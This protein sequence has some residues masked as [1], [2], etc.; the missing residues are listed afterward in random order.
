MTDRLVTDWALWCTAAGHAP[1]TIRLRT[2]YVGRCLA[3]REAAS[4]T[5]ADVARFLAAPGWRPA[6]R[7]SAHAA[8]R[9][10][11]GWAAGA[12][13]L[14]A[15]PTVGLRATRVPV[16]VP[17]PASDQVIATALAAADRRGRL[18]LL[19]AATM[20]LRRAE[21]A[22]AHSRDVVDGLLR[23][24]G[25]GGRTRLVPVHPQVAA[26][27]AGTDGWLFPGPTGHLRPETVGRIMR[28]L[29]RDATAHQLRHRAATRAYA[30]TR[31]ILAVQRLLGHAS[32]ATTMVYTA[33]PDGAV[34]AAVLAAGVR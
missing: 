16:G 30:G 23:V 17:R 28:R 34:R 21:I 4:L 14:E 24:R 20:G 27:V 11:Y 10:F 13:L 29:L 25:K 8:L 31:D 32:V 9:A 22:A 12:G 15:D 33:V 6:T 5:A 19:L 18:M 1:S 26:A 2:Y 7:R 3:G